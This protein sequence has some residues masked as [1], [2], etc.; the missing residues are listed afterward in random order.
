MV[1]GF[2]GLVAAF[3]F[4]WSVAEVGVPQR[5]AF[6]RVQGHGHG[7]APAL[8][9][10]DFKILG[11]LITCSKGVYVALHVQRVTSQTKYPYPPTRGCYMPADH[12][13]TSA[14]HDDEVTR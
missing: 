1:E 13:R 10:F 12:K 5:S 11:I 8:S 2:K 6:E 7:P 4:F 14:T 9:W 3:F